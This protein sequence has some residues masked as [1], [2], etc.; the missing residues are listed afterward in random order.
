MGQKRPAVRQRLGSLITFD[1]SRL[2]PFCGRSGQRIV[3]VS[4]KR[5]WNKSREEAGKTSQILGETFGRLPSPVPQ[6]IVFQKM[7]RFLLRYYCCPFCVL[8]EA[9]ILL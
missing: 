8:V 5:T 6:Y 7:N 4:D 2:R 3:G 1:Q 9:L